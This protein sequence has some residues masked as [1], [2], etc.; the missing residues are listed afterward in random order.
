MN[1]YPV[2]HGDIHNKL[3]VDQMLRQYFPDYDY[4]GV[5]LDVGAFEP[6]RISNSY[7]FEKNGWTVYC[8]EANS[9]LIPLLKSS[10]ANVYNYAI[11]DQ[12]KDNIEFNVVHTPIH[13]GLWTAAI[14]A[15]NLDSRYLKDHGHAIQ[16]IDKIIVN[17]RTL[18]SLLPTDIKVDILSIDVEGSE[19]NVLKGIDLDNYSPKVILVE[20]IYDDQALN[21]Y[22]IKHGYK[23]DKVNSYNKFYLK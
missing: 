7:H 19:L 15:I 6:I 1:I 2:F 4:K 20:D 3:A 12:N 14:S 17:Q 16:K 5:F 8:F 10:R 11:A 18:N 23:L 13:N 21:Q 9:N 22:I